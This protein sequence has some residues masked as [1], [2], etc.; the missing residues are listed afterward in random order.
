VYLTHPLEVV[1]L[2]LGI[3]ALSQKKLNDAATG[4]IKKFDDIFRRLDTIHER[5]RHRPTAKTA[6]THSIVGGVA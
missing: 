3:G 6:L 2:A 1:P 4:P 5:D